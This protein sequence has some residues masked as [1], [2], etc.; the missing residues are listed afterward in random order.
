M[1]D[2]EETYIK[3]ALLGKKELLKEYVYSDSNIGD[4]ETP[5]K[6]QFSNISAENYTQIRNDNMTII[7]ADDAIEENILL[8]RKCREIT[9]NLIIILGK[10]RNEYAVKLLQVGADDYIK[11]PISR[12]VLGILIYA[13]I[14]REN[15]AVLSLL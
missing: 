15:R 6:Y 10:A 2:K 5:Y 13:H 4:L 11:A 3:I 12:R 9:D 7:L 14:R 8:C 1:Q